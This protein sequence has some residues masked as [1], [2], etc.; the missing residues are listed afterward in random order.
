MDWGEGAGPLVVAVGE[1][2]PL[3]H[4]YVED[5]VYTV[6]ICVDDGTDETCEVITATVNN[7]PAVIGT[8]T[9]TPAT[10][11]EGDTVTLDVS[12]TDPGVTDTHTAVI[13][14]G[15]GATTPLDPATSPFSLDHTYV[16]EGV[17]GF[18]H[19]RHHHHRRR[20]RRRDS[21]RCRHRDQLE[22]PGRHR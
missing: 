9:A 3:D 7:A 11:T 20:R 1:G 17:D 16:D 6:T 2:V 4:T 22:P 19:R 14:W 8:A 21:R 5:G 18:L 13:D 12:F 10:I 15:D